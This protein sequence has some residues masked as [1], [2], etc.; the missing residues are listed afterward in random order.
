VAEF[1]ISTLFRYSSTAN[2]LYAG[3]SGSMTWSLVLASLRS[4]LQRITEAVC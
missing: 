1:G 2:Q 3:P 4:M